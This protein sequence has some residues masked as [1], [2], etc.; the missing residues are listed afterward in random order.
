MTPSFVPWE[1]LETRMKPVAISTLI[2]RLL[3]L[4]IISHWKDPGFLGEAGKSRSGTGNEQEE[5]GTPGQIRKQGSH[6][7]L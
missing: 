2:P 4:N 5:P 6:H 7:I 3:S 1:G